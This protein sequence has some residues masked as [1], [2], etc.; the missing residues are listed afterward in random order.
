MPRISNDKIKKIEEQI[1]YF[2]FNSFPK[3]FYTFEI[4]KEIARDEEFIKNLL[5]SMEKKGLIIKVDKNS[6]GIKYER[7][8]RWRISNKTYEIYKQMQ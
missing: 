6:N 1:L 8:L 2:L 4:S 3:N 5:L 7:R